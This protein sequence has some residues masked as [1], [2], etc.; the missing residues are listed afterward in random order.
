MRVNGGRETLVP[1]PSQSK[2]PH[3]RFC[4]TLENILEILFQ[5][6]LLSIFICLQIYRNNFRGYRC[7][8][9][10]EICILL[11]LW[12]HDFFSKKAEK[13]VKKSRKNCSTKPTKNITN[14]FWIFKSFASNYWIL[15]SWWLLKLVYQ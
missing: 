5:K 4:P 13:I 14:F 11:T 1:N 15:P 9:I 2:A 6:N 8:I 10:W 7:P 3:C 12:Q